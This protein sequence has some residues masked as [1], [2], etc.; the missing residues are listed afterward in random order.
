MAPSSQTE[1]KGEGNLVLAVPFKKVVYSFTKNKE[2]TLE[3][4]KRIYAI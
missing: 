3:S 4:T 2:R 1:N